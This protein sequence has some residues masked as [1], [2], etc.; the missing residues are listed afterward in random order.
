MKINVEGGSHG[1]LVWYEH[2]T[3]LHDVFAHHWVEHDIGI[4][5]DTFLDMTSLPTSNEPMVAI[6]TTGYFSN[7]L[8]VY[9][10]EDTAGSWVDKSMVHM[11]IGI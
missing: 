6:F 10:T 1:E 8:K 11:N 2:P 7:Q 3:L 5:S 4:N 9:W